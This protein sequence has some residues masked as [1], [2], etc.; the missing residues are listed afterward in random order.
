[1]E[2]VH[3]ANPF[4]ALPVEEV[5]EDEKPVAGPSSAIKPWTTEPGPAAGEE[6]ARSGDLCRREDW[7]CP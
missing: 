6:K 2:A 7:S 5:F 1:M 4:S 3:V